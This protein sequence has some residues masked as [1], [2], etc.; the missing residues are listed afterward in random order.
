MKRLKEL[1][2]RRISGYIA[3][4]YY[5]CTHMFYNTQLPNWVQHAHAATLKGATRIISFILFMPFRFLSF[6]ATCHFKW[7]ERTPVLYYYV[8]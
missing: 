8:D 3:A 7:W 6:I 4:I 2:P 1:Q 5:S